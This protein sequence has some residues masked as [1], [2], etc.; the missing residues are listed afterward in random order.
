MQ[1]LGRQSGGD[2][3]KRRRPW[4]A[5]PA[6]QEGAD[7]GRDG[8]LGPRGHVTLPQE[9]GDVTGGV[10]VPKIGEEGGE[11]KSQKKFLSWSSKRG[12]GRKKRS[13]PEA[14]D[15]TG[16]DCYLES[17]VPGHVGAH[18]AAPKAAGACKNLSGEST[19]PRR[20]R[21]VARPWSR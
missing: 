18:L 9:C 2:G 19:P 17:P 3:W 1:D 15:Y 11:K 7:W 4:K 16:P 13:R 12:V 10:A 20:P 5:L 6:R 14:R 21:A 8:G